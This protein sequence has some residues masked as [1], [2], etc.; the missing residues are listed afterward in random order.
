MREHGIIKSAQ[1]KP[2]KAEKQWKTRITIKNKAM[3]VKQ[4][5]IWYILI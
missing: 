2:K 1:L 5:Q 4:E 3:N